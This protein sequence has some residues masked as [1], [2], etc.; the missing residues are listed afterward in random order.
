MSVLEYVSKG[1]GP[2]GADE[3]KQVSD[4]DPLPSS[5]VLNGSVTSTS[6]QAQIKAYLAFAPGTGYS[7]N[8]TLVEVQSYELD[9]NGGIRKHWY[10]LTT[11]AI[12][13]VDPS[14]HIE[15]PQPEIQYD[16][17]YVEYKATADNLPLYSIGDTLRQVL[18]YEKNNINAFAEF[19]S[20]GSIFEKWHNLTNQTEFATRLEQSQIDNDLVHYSK[21]D[22]GFSSI[23]QGTC[24]AAQS[25]AGNNLLPIPAGYEGIKYLRFENKDTAARISIA[26]GSGFGEGVIPNFNT[27]DNVPSFGQGVVISPGEVFEKTFEKPVSININFGT[28]IAPSG[29]NNL[30]VIIE[31]VGR[32]QI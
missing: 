27:I 6:S 12:L 10:N 30:G 18:V 17:K 8:D 31:A 9:A 20:T 19:L 7:V 5:A 29:T 25:N 22:K 15:E 21:I 2:N 24:S 13:T 23:F 11:Q 4:L 28:D 1:T 14:M 26:I 32:T 3:I 16:Q